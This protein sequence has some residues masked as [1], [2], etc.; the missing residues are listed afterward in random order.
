MVC[1]LTWA[2][3]PALAQTK[4]P[5][6]KVLGWRGDGTGVFKD[7]TPVTEWGRWPKSPNHGLRFQIKKPKTG[8]VAQDAA[9]VK[10]GQVLEWLVAG[11]FPAKDPA[12]ALD[13]EFLA[14]EASTSP[15]EGQKAGNL[16]WQK[17]VSVAQD[18][19]VSMDWIQLSE[20]LGKKPGK[21]AYAHN[22]L[23]SATKGTI[24]FHLDQVVG[25]KVWINGKLVH[26][27]PKPVVTMH[28]INYVCYA[29][30]THWA[31]ELP[32]LGE[33]ASQ[34]IRVD[35]EQ[36][37]NR[38]LIKATGNVNLRFVEAPETQYETKNIV[39]TCRLPNYS[40]AQPIIV[41]DRIFV[42]SESEDLICVNKNTGK[43]LWKRAT[44]YTDCLTGPNKTGTGSEPTIAN[45]AEKACGKVPV[46]V[47][48]GPLSGQ[49][50]Q[51]NPLLKQAAQLTER[52]R[53]AADTD[54]RIKLRNEIKD[55]LAKTDQKAAA[56]DPRY[57]E[58]RPL[59]E[60]LKDEGL[61]AAERKESLARIRSLLAKVE[62]PKEGNP[63]YS[64][65]L[66]LEEAVKS[67][68][69]K[70]ADRAAMLREIDDV[71]IRAAP[72]PRFRTP[73]HT[74]I[75]ATGFTSPVPASDG[76]H[77]YVYLGWG[78]VA[79]YDLDGNRR[80]ARLATDLGGVGAFNNNSPVLVGGKLI[81]LRNV[82]MRAYDAKTGE[83]AW[84][85]PDL[86]PKTHVDVWHGFGTDGNP[87]ASLC[88]F[89]LGGKDVAY[90]NSAIVRVEDGHVYC[91]FYENFGSNPRGTPVPLADALYY[92]VNT[93]V[94]RFP[95][96]ADFQPGMRLQKQS[97]EDYEGDVDTYSS[98]LVHDGLLYALR[99]DGKLWV[100]DA[101][102][103]AVVYSRKL[104]VESYRDYDHPGVTPSLSLAGKH[105]FAFDNQGNAIV[106]EP[107]RQFQ[108]VARNRLA[109]CVS[110][111]WVLDPDEIFQ[112]AP[113]FEGGRMYLR[114]EQNLY[115]IG[116]N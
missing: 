8:D 25:C 15:D 95:L 65:V 113:I 77:V 7:A 43:I 49:E 41:G 18:P 53:A 33:S 28:S 51:A 66:P 74:H 56:A 9:P 81:I 116:K 4:S 22:Y 110:R 61:P 27:N 64:S 47:L 83:V 85:T 72:R 115:C 96:P 102:T 114:G 37:W 32:V 19:G 103:L 86:R 88:A 6:T 52:L 46:P 112:S 11:P 2:L 14:D 99:G 60:K 26:N 109:T 13:E 1:G 104:D 59:Q 31:G 55:L 67:P 36:G 69:T 92:G 42:M 34:K 68:E 71:L 16:V 30:T 93:A 82:Q 45:S 29:A 80:W 87:S 90:V 12:K 35:L 105:I 97:R 40:N 5:A 108:Q 75:Q 23:F 76:R 106:I 3:S 24:V 89:K 94:F 91:P 98:V 84:T 50:K 111:K 57:A 62:G 38:V 101:K 54:E 107:G 58:I 10:S 73:L 20:L 39:W 44:F 100:Y 70:E 17:H 78:I 21:A 79:C 48:L 63:H